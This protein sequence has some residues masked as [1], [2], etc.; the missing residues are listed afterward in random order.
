MELKDYWKAL[1]Y[2]DWH[3]AYSDDGSVYRRG[4]AEEQ[5]LKGIASQSAEHMAL[6]KSMSL[7]ART[8]D[9]PLPPCPE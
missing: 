3:Y 5:R 6:W 2:H 9:I 1:R 4:A 8:A 7:W